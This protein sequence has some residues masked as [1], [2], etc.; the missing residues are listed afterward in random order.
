[1]IALVGPDGAGKST[2]ARALEAWRAPELD[3]EHAHMGRPPRAAVTLAIGA[4]VKLARRLASVLPHRGRH[5]RDGYL[6]LLRC[7]CTARD[8]SLLHR[9]LRRRAAAGAIVIC[10]RY[11]IPE[12]RA[13]VGPSYAQGVA[14][15]VSGPL[16]TLLRRLESRYY[17]RLSRPDLVLVLRVD[18]ETA[19]RRKPEEPEPYVR[20]R[21]RILWNA[22]W[23]SDRVELVDAGE[24][25]PVVIAD[26]RA[27]IWEAL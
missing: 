11:P 2:C 1:V 25:L 20:A 23:S 26:L 9:R 13:L 21:A 27:R 18:P 3:V 4:A 14:T 12:N 22:E 15:D 17:A 5:A 8:R 19:V 16:A 6:I 7:A 10:E 24:S